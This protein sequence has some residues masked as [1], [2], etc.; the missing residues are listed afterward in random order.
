MRLPVNQLAAS[1][2]LI[3]LAGCGGGDKPAPLPAPLAER[4]PAADYPIVLGDPFTV[5][6]V[7]Y[8]PVDRLNYDAVGHATVGTEGGDTVSI[9]H[10]TLPLPS[11]AE[12]TAL[13]N[14]KTVLVRVERRGPMRGDRLVELSPGAAAQLGI[15]ADRSPIRIRRVNPPE[16]E[17]AMLRSGARAPERM[18]TPASLLAVLK[19]RLDPPA[20]MPASSAAEATPTVGAS[21]M[22][23][24]SPAARPSPTPRT[25]PTPA[26]SPTPSATPSPAP[27]EGGLVVQVGAFANAA[28][29]AAVAARIG[30]SQRRSGQF[31]RV[32]LG[33]FATR[34]EA[35][36]ALA[37][38]RAAG[39]S[40]SRIQRA[41]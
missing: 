23:Q 16:V 21:P 27:R 14:G 40:D 2:A 4:G 18:N 38:A 35:E 12:I 22:P 30:G 24:A 10:K 1:A 11:Y 5:D 6:G 15:E 26:S 19:R 25:R 17:R 29:A 39:Y 13:D 28:N 3:L 33:P 8:T 36:A 41:D 7:T 9:A 32:I 31:S 37:K 34:A 20:P